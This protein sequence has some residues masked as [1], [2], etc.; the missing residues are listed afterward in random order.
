LGSHSADGAGAGAG[1]SEGI[2]DGDGGGAGS[3]ASASARDGGSEIR[4]S[5]SEYDGVMVSIDV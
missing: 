1:A 3:S 5:V 2:S 4:F